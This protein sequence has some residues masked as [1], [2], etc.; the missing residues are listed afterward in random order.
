M[1]IITGWVDFQFAQAMSIG[2]KLE[3][4]EDQARAV[5]LVF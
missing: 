3:L 2:N 5:L 4:H 1:I